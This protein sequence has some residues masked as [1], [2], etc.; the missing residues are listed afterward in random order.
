MQKL[1]A[2][3]FFLNFS[4]SYSQEYLP[5]ES[6]YPVIENDRWGYMNR[7]GQII[8]KAQFEQAGN[9]SEGVA[10][11]RTS[12]RYGYINTSGK[13]VIEQ[14]FDFAYAFRNGYALIYKNAIP[15]IIR[16][17]GQP[18]FKNVYPDLIMVNENRFII[19]TANQ[20]KG[21]ADGHGKLIVDTLFDVITPTENDLYIVRGTMNKVSSYTDDV[22]VID[23][24]GQFIVPYGIYRFIWPYKNGLA[25]V[26][27]QTP[28]KGWD[29][30]GFIDTKGSL[31][32]RITNKKIFRAEDFSGQF[33]KVSMLAKETNYSRDDYYEG[34]MDRTG[35]LVVN[36]QT[37]SHVYGFTNNRAFAFSRDDG[38]Y[39][40]DGSGKPMNGTSY[41]DIK[42]E[43][44]ADGR[45]FVCTKDGWQVIDTN[46]TVLM[47]QEVVFEEATYLTNALFYSLRRKWRFWDLEKNQAPK[48]EFDNYDP[49]GFCDGLLMIYNKQRLSYVD[50]S[51]KKIWE[52]EANDDNKPRPLNIDYMKRGYYYAYSSPLK[53]E[54][55]GGWAISK[56]LPRQN[57]KHSWIE[58]EKLNLRLSD[59]DTVVNGNI[60]AKKLF[61]VNATSDTAFFPAQ[62]SRLY[63][64]I[65]ALDPKEG[66]KDIEYLPN[67]DCG[68]SYHT[69]QLAPR[70]YWTFAAPVYAGGF[71]TKLRAALRL[72]KTG[73]LN[74]RDDKSIIIYSNEF[75][76]SIN[77]AQFWRKLEYLPGG[78]MDP[79]ND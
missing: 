60:Q 20:M 7:Q 63:L 57:A 53:K 37:F 18:L 65:Q 69:L 24:K 23:D 38:F 11:V 21:I 39:L 30:N 3:F 41:L 13:V 73:K 71:T 4:C 5:A 40:L 10:A 50:R 29:Y 56:N 62:N 17:N 76:G 68:N 9:F 33:C 15:Q 32:I 36:D 59:E 31:A 66:W 27:V 25:K 72:Y 55:H 22:G 70:E 48:I 67:S 47:K 75:E 26:E 28:D 35:N 58:K 74:R 14:S 42:Q 64:T 45:A 77:P 2:I 51:G 34:F 79:Y 44:F 61:I 8:I 16:E 19:T 43:G 46:A 12:G 6:L 54:V 78:P 52:Q 49:S 1:I